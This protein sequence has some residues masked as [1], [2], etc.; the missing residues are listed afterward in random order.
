MADSDVRWDEQAFLIDFFDEWLY[1][2]EDKEYKHFTQLEGDNVGIINSLLAENCGSETNSFFNFTTAQ[3]S[4]LVPTIRVFKVVYD[5]TYD[6]ELNQTTY[7]NPRNIEFKFQD[8]TSIR[9]ITDSSRGRGTDVGIKSFSWQD[10]GTNPADSG[11][12]FKAE[13]KLFFQSMEAVFLPRNEGVRFADMFVPPGTNTAGEKIRQS[14]DKNAYEDQNF[15]IKVIVGWSVPNDANNTLFTPLQL[16]AIGK[17]RVSLLMTLEDHSIDFKQNGNLEISLNYIA[18]IEGR[19]LHSDSDLLYVETGD[20]EKLLQLREQEANLAEAKDI[21]RAA[22]KSLAAIKKGDKG[23]ALTEE[24]DAIRKNSELLINTLQRHKGFFGFGG[25]DADD[26]N[27]TDEQKDEINRTIADRESGQAAAPL[28][29]STRRAAAQA[30][31]EHFQGKK[32]VTKA[33]EARIEIQEKEINE[34]EAYIEELNFD[35]RS[36]SYSRLLRVITEKQ[37]IYTFPVT[38]ELV[39]EW[40]DSLARFSAITDVEA[41][42]RRITNNRF[43]KKSKIR[44]TFQYSRGPTTSLGDSN[45]ELNSWNRDYISADSKKRQEMLDKL[46]GDDGQKYLKNLFSQNATSDPNAQSDKDNTV[47]IKFFFFGDIID[48]ALE[49]LVNKDAIPDQKDE[50][51]Y[52]SSLKKELKMVLGCVPLYYYN[53]EGS[54]VRA[55]VPLSDIPISLEFFNTWFVKKVVKP[56]RNNYYLRDFLRDIAA[57]M[58]DNA[59]EPFIFGPIGRLKHSSISFS[60]FSLPANERTES[61]FSPGRKERNI[62]FGGT[63]IPSYDE[64]F[65]KTLLSNIFM[66]YYKSSTNRDMIGSRVPNDIDQVGDIARGI[67]HFRFGASRG[68]V[69][70]INFSKQDIPGAREARILK[71][72]SIAGRNQL[73]SNKYDCNVTLFGTPMFKPG[74]LV[75]VDPYSLGIPNSEN[76]AR[77]LGLGGYYSV[78]GADSFAESGKYETSLKMVFEAPAYGATDK[79]EFIRGNLLYKPKSFTIGGE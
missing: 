1:L 63:A 24:E 9:S 30:Y 32:L 46:S 10:L 45:E 26:F 6:A 5:T 25:Y 54:T 23:Y 59:I 22:E 79:E 38:N 76:I 44:D 7:S 33:K 77:N 2:Q 71:S 65:G 3:Q 21:K 58:I 37:R 43:K 74:M 29:D 62:D 53:E 8:K 72:Q 49:I 57:E 12:A 18:A 17:Q 34:L 36:K 70:S 55:S 61:A 13:L 31:L 51:K 67:M 27:L 4:A 15:Q 68:I 28:S 42:A 78:V 14:D 16:E 75:Y 66:M 20:R 69:K 73:F 41:Q 50:I 40:K 48:A 52:K 35:L 64:D 11:V 47:D 60:T 56:L 39:K 19:M